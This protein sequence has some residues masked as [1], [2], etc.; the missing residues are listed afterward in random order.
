MSGFG[1]FLVI[2]ILVLNFG[3]SWWNARACGRAW[4]ELQAVGGAVRVLVWCGATQSAIGFSMVFLLPI[5]FAAHAIDPQ[6]VTD[7]VV[8]DIFD[9]WYVSIIIPALG[10]GLA[11][12]IE[13]WIAAYRD[14]SLANLGVAA[15]NSFAQVHNTMGAVRGLG[16]ALQSVGGLFTGKG[17]ARGKAIILVVVIVVFALTAGVVL[18]A[19]LIQHYAGTVPLPARAAA[20]AAGQPAA[21]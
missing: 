12:T 1:G 5:T 7:G 21:S 19:V 20:G 18:T 16:P 3:I 17:D 10:T 2:F 13:S 14:R 8:A 15:Y 6:T 9:L 4:A 11:I